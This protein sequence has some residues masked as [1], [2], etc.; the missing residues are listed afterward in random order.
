MTAISHIGPALAYLAQ[1]K[2]N[3]DARWKARLASLREHTAA[4]R[5]LNRRAA[6]NW[7]DRL[8]EPAWSTHKAEIRAMVDYACART[9]AYIDSLGDG[10]RLHR[11]RRQRGFLQRHLGRNTRCRSST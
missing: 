11:R 6:G 5:A 1:I 8:N 7:L 2:A 3:G 4:V 9:L 10:D